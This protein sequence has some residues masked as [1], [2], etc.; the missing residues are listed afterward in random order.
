MQEVNISLTIDELNI[1]TAGLGKLPMEVS[2]GIFMKIKMQVEAQQ[3]QPEAVG[4]TD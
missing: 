3:V 2:M 4:G 1:V